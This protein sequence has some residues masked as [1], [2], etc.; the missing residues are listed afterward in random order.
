MRRLLALML[1]LAVLAACGGGDDDGDD[2]IAEAA[3]VAGGDDG[4]SGGG[5]GEIDGCDL[6]T[7]DD[8]A[9]MLGETP[10]RQPDDG[11]GGDAVLA[12]CTWIVEH[13]TG[14]KM[15]LIHVFNGPQFFAP[16]V[17]AEEETFEKVDGVGEDA[18][19]WGS[20]LGLDIQILV[21]DVTVALGASGFNTDDPG[22]NPATVRERLLA[23]AEKVVDRL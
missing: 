3:D 14:F 7:Q 9:A 4:E 21:D 20:P 8:A 18:F 10:Q 1:A 5:D 11:L 15:A 23:Q 16:E 6:L 22:Y 13:E 17:Y 2:G 19:M 12:E